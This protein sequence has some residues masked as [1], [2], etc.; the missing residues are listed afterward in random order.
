MGIAGIFVISCGWYAGCMLN[1]ILAFSF[2]EPSAGATCDK[3]QRPT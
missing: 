2:P 1:S 3:Y